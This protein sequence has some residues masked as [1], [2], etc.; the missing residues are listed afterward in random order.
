[1]F[2]FGFPAGTRPRA[3][4]L[5]APVIV[6][7]S[8]VLAACATTTTG[9]G[10]SPSPTSTTPATATTA[11]AASGTPIKVYFSQAPAALE[12][13]FTTVTAVNRISPTKGVGTFAIQMLVAGPTP[14]ERA[15]GMFSEMNSMFTGPSVCNGSLPVG[16]PDFTLTLNMKGST[17]EQGTATLKF[18]RPTSLAGVGA[19]AR[20]GTEINRT[21]L[22]FPTIKKVVILDS[23]GTCWNDLSGLNQCLK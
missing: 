13:D 21:L 1:M 18:C 19:G 23:N 9:T 10:G 3:I 2:R 4:R 17:S 15:Q 7:L 8:L 11:P 5:A 22:Q 6:S 14:D 16:G 20:I 12:S